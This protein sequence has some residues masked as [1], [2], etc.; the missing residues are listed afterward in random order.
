MKAVIPCGG[1]GT[2]FLPITKA[3]PKELL[4]IVDVPVLSH[5]IDECVQSGIHEVLIVIS[6]QKQIIKDYFSNNE[7]LYEDLMRSGKT[8]LAA[9]V[10][11]VCGNAEIS[12]VV[13]E[14]PIGSAHAVAITK[15]FV[16][17]NPF[18]LALG[19]DLIVGS[20]PVTKQLVDA[21]NDV[22]STIIGVQRHDGDD[23]TKY[24]V[25]DVALESGK[26]SLLKGI[27]EKPPLTALPSRLACYGRYVLHDIFTYIDK[28]QAG[29]DGEYQITDALMLQCMAAK[30]YAYE[31]DGKRY[32]MGDK[33]GSLQAAIELSLMRKDF[34]EELKRYIKELASRI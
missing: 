5:I 28:I 16:G 34:G 27:V 9:T 4:P 12:F 31:F 2:R 26:L 10:A 7:R 11:S 15:P 3:V 8:E 20:P 18:V 24:G 14:K 1:M 32:D 33:F 25:A 6:P 22:K 29:K 23:I 19:D 21:Y 13:Q 17:D 30:V